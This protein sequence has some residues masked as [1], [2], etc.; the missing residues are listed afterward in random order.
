MG[1][2]PRGVVSGMSTHRSSV[3]ATS[4][5]TRGQARDQRGRRVPSGA[6]AAWGSRTTTHLPR[7]R[8]GASDMLRS[9]TPWF[10]APP[11][12]P[13]REVVLPGRG[14]TVV[15]ESKGPPD[16]PTLMLLHGLG[17][18]AA[19]N[20]FTSFPLFERRFHLV[21]ADLR[22][23]GRGIRAA[24]PFTLEDAADDVVALAGRVGD[25]S[26][27]SG[28]LLDGPARSPNSC[29]AVIT[30]EWP[31]SSCARPAT[32]SAPPRRNT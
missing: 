15:L 27:R 19:L 31:G 2:T 5:R 28:R 25:R 6:A 3:S 26:V 4:P 23:H 17:V 9:R 12:P 16:A 7:R 13:A 18:T 32:R 24:T 14:T 10:P 22:G 30:I 20:W 11:L 8:R 1:N 29:G 21:A